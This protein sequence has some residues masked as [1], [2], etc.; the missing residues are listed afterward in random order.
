MKLTLLIPA[1]LAFAFATTA[2]ADPPMSGDR[3]MRHLDQMAERL[4]LDEQQRAQMHE[5]MEA[6][7]ERMKASREHLHEAL[8]AMLTPEQA[9]K[10]DEMHRERQEHHGEHGE[11]K[12]HDKGHDR[13]RH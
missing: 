10:L 12:G 9:A 3:M 6:H 8:M 2:V 5:L 4:D 7:H 11:T 13:H 1:A